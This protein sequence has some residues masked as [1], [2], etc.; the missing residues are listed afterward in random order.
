[1]PVYQFQTT[2]VR[3][4]QKF[5]ASFH[6]L[7]QP[8]PLQTGMA[9]GGDD[10]MVVNLDFEVPRRLDQVAGQ[11]DV[12][13]AGGGIAAGMVVDDDQG[14]GVELQRAGDDVADIDGRFVDRALPHLLVGDQQILGV[15]VEQGSA[16][17]VFFA[18]FCGSWPKRFVAFMSADGD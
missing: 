18:V 1:M 8:H 9:V 7:N 5:P 11:A 15:A 12:L 17:R 10:D 14:G 6:D 4:Q 3:A 16:N 2:S 13:L